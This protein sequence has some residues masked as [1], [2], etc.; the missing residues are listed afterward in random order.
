M[1][2]ITFIFLHDPGNFSKP[3]LSVYEIVFYNHSRFLVHITILDVLLFLLI[4]YTCREYILAVNL[5]NCLLLCNWR[6]L[7][8]WK[9]ECL[10]FV[11][12]IKLIEYL[13]SCLVYSNQYIFWGGRGMPVETKNIH[14][15][16]FLQTFFKV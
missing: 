3:F 1:F 4:L 9:T 10:V 5:S 13:K 16:I 12:L 2:E 11:R 6:M 14:S 7:E 15:Y 8:I